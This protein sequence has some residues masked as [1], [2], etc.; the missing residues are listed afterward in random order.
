V[1]VA[2]E[3]D[4]LLIVRHPAGA[5]LLSARTKVKQVLVRYRPVETKAE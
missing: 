3:R 5:D 4:D 2:W 1:S